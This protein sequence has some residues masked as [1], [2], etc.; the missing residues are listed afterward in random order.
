MTYRKKSRSGKGTA[1]TGGDSSQSMD[2]LVDMGTSVL[3]SSPLKLW[4]G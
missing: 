1:A 3:L 2:R 4:H